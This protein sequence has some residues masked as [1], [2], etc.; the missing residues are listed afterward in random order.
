M[1]KER[2][3]RPKASAR[4]AATVLR[5]PYT[6]HVLYIYSTYLGAARRGSFPI[7]PVSSDWSWGVA[8]L[9]ELEMPVPGGGASLCRLCARKV[10]HGMDVGAESD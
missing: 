5:A 6:T 3:R 2:L 4:A 9:S 7:P 8:S 10:S 1:G